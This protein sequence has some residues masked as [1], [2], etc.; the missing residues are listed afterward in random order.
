ME[1]SDQGKS[2]FTNDE[3]VA[4]ALRIRE[5]EDMIL[6]GQRLLTVALTQKA[7]IKANESRLLQRLTIARTALADVRDHWSFFLLPK[8]LKK[9]INKELLGAD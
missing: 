8:W 3:G 4:Q 5:L 7:S 9:D 1:N 2:M 6:T